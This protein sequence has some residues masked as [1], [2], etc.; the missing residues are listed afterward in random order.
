MAKLHEIKVDDDKKTMYVKTSGFFKE[1][2]ALAYI[3]EFQATLKKI[4]VPTFKLIVDAIDQKAVPQNVIDEV[5]GALKLYMDC[6][7]KKVVILTPSSPTA[8][9]QAQSCAKEIN[10][11]GEFVDNLEMAYAI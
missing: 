2:D 10:F 9:M 3:N 6:G 5:K 4:N 11:S 7:F 8:K 1:E